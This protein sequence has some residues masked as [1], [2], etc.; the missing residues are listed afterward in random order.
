MK[1]PKKYL[2]LFLDETKALLY[3][4]TSMPD[5]SPQVTPVWF[6]TDDDHI[7]INTNEGRVKDINMKNRPKVA[8][9]IQDPNDP[10]R[11]LQIR[12]EVLEFTRE[13][14][15]EHINT[16]SQKY[17]GKPWIHTEGQKRITFKIKPAHFDPL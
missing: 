7:L 11:Y 8:M 1:L 15:D 13:A 10:Y 16:L 5:G 4:A 14:A 9:V 17:D 2:D 3:L 12:G 6:N